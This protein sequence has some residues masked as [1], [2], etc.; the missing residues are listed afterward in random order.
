MRQVIAG[1]PTLVFKNCTTEEQVKIMTLI[2]YERKDLDTIHVEDVFRSEEFYEVESWIFAGDKVELLATW[3]TFNSDGVVFDNK[4][5][6]HNE[7][8]IV[9]SIVAPYVKHSNVESP[10]SVGVDIKV[11]Y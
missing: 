10:A 5:L 8:F 4:N 9:N 3:D 11:V 1:V 7:I 6:P 2:R